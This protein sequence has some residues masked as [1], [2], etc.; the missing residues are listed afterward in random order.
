MEVFLFISI[1]MKEMR[2]SSRET[3]NI[4]HVVDDMAARVE[5]TRVV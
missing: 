4:T 3:H 5:R 2:F 1:G